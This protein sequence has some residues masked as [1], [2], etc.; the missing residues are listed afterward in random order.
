MMEAQI[1]KP[2]EKEQA[3]SCLLALEQDNKITFDHLV[4]AAKAL[5]DNN[6][7]IICNSDTAEQL[8]KNQNIVTHY[9]ILVAKYIDGNECFVF[10][11]SVISKLP[12]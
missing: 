9:K 7:T 1:D 6:K 11:D 12:E 4:K 5:T 10:D 3:I 2:S 8:R